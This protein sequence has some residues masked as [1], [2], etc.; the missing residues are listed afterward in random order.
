MELQDREDLAKQSLALY[1]RA[2]KKAML[3]IAKR[4]MYLRS[5][6]E[7]AKEDMRRLEEGR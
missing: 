5:E 3:D 4:A 2:G 7:R 6:I 1:E